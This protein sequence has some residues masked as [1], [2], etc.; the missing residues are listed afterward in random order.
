M[1]AALAVPV[2]GAS[3]VE[4][5]RAALAGHARVARARRR[6]RA[7]GRG[8][9]RHPRVV[10]A[11]VTVLATSRRRLPV[12][13]DAGGAAARRRRGARA[14]PGAAPGGH[15]PLR[16]AEAD[17]VLAHLD[18][19]PLAIELA[20]GRLRVL[21]PDALAAR[22]ADGARVLGGPLRARSSGPG[23]P[24]TP[25]SGAPWPQPP[26]PGATSPPTRSRPWSPRSTR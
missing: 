21:R 20:A 15:A 4:R 10:R 7:D 12:A 23:T 8:G 1:Q 6:R 11:G 16:D 19:L 25:T 14:A 26:S 22:L 17:A 24:S 13:R 3:V 18:G 5:V 9:C 2:E